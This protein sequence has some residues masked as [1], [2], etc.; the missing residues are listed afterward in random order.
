MHKKIL[1]VVGITIIF[2]GVGIQPVLANEVSIAKTSDAEEDCNCKPVSSLH[3]V[4]LK[5]LLNR[6]DKHYNLLSILSKINP[7][8]SEKYQELYDNIDA[9]TEY[10]NEDIFELSWNFPILCGLIE[11]T[12]NNLYLLFQY[13]A[14]NWDT[15]PWPLSSILLF[16]SIPLFPILLVIFSIGLVFRCF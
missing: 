5:S 6:L 4:R 7:E 8:L 10:H 14:K 2:L 1:I 13:L 9:L 3:L 11:K 16:F 12:Y 15:Y